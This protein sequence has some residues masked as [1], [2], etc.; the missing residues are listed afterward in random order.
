M[1][2]IDWSHTKDLTTFDGKRVRVETT[3]NLLRRLAK[4]SNTIVL[5][6]GVPLSLIYN[7]A[8]KGIMVKLIDNKATEIYR[9]K[10]KLE[11]T[12]ENDARIIYKLANNGAKL[13]EITSDDKRLQMHNLYHQ[14]CRFQKARVAI[15]NMR[16][17]HLRQYGGVRETI[18]LS[19]YDTAIDTLQ[20]REKSLL[21]KLGEMA[22]VTGGE[23][24]ALMKSA[25]LFQPPAIRGLGN[26]IWLGLV[27]TANPI[28]FKCLSA[29][30]R[31]CGLTED[32]VKSHKYN[33]HAK[34][35]YHMLAKEIMRQRDPI[36]RPIYD[37]CKA[38]II[39]G[40]P[41]YTKLH[42]HNATLNRTATFLAK[43]VFN[44]Y[45][46][47]AGAE[48]NIFVKPKTTLQAPASS[49]PLGKE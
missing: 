20:A 16:K 24:T 12:D 34:M 35:L 49:L 23:S 15:E 13:Q 40:H 29:Y 14:Y 8:S 30:L 2:A 4:K 26:R 17:A 21:K 37:K 28:N 48:S 5:E 27:V 36:F 22:F 31:F 41:D 25:D 10:H 11:K 44:S 19:P 33:R 3:Q 1:L 46:N 42:I 38:D 6:Q 7:L 32:A 47:N 39:K 9:K 43:M 18:D 45:G